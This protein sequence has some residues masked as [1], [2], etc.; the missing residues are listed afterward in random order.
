MAAYC[1]EL[2]QVYLL[3]IELAANRRALQLRISPP[4]NCQ[5]ASIHFETDFRLGAVAQSEERLSGTQEAGGSSP[6]SSI[7]GSDAGIPLEV[8]AHEFRNRFGWYMERAAAGEKFL[9]TRRGK[10]KVR[11]VPADPPA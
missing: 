9:V 8:G 7:S 10:P 3:P 6:P 2:D 1:P 11:L 5:R 4:K